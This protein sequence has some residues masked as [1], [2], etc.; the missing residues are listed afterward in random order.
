MQFRAG[1]IAGSPYWE[2]AWEL[3]A[4]AVF[5]INIFWKEKEQPLG[6]FFFF[7][8]FDRAFY[9]IIHVLNGRGRG[10]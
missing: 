10:T 6:R 1:I 5:F 7:C 4:V 9:H 8:C 3:G 2:R